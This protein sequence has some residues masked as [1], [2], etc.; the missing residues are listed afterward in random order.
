[1]TNFYDSA[2]NDLA[3]LVTDDV[4]YF[5]NTY[6]VKIFESI[7]DPSVSNKSGGEVAVYL[8]GVLDDFIGIEVGHIITLDNKTYTVNNFR[9]TVYGAI[10]IYIKRKTI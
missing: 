10:N 5:G 4:I 2:K 1:M 8:L 3:M 9:K 7:D 6:K